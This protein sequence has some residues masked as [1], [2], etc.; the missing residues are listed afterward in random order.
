MGKRLTIYTIGH[1]N[2]SKE[3]FLNLLR[4]HSIQILVDVRRWPTSKTEHFKLSY[5][6]E[7]LPKIG[8]EY[9]WLGD[10]LGGYR[11]GGYQAYTESEMFKEG[12]KSLIELAKRGRVC[13]MCLEIKPSGC[14]RRF[15]AKKLLETGC[16]II[17]IISEN[18]CIRVDDITRSNLDCINI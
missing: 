8:I 4:K 3:L 13:I 17:H 12:L 15:I 10:H 2:R 16:E 14:H 9:V 1:G 11:R 18:E 5:L 7:W 6:R